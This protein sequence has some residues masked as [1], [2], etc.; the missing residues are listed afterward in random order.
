MDRADQPAERHLGRK[1]TY[2][3]V[4]GRFTR[5]I[6]HEQQHPGNDLD[7]EKEHR[8][9]A[10]VVP[11]HPMRTDGDFFVAQEL[12]KRRELI[13][14][15]QPAAYAA[16]FLGSEVYVGSH[17]R[18]GPAPSLLKGA[19]KFK[20]REMKGERRHGNAP[21]GASSPFRS[22]GSG[23]RRGVKA[24]KVVV[25]GNCEM[26][27]TLSLQRRRFHRQV[28]V[29]QRTWS[30]AEGADRTTRDRSDRQ[31]GRRDKDTR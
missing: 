8:D 2:A 18:N 20:R 16:S 10:K 6:V 12:E 29:G 5:L 19:M 3:L 17:F 28:D 24:L 31:N 23:L 27:L 15:V 7:N 25:C 4:R 22:K 13:S 30:T 11:T 1:K 26:I 14:P 21:I 9:P